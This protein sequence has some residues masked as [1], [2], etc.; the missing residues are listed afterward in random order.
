[1][2]ICVLVMANSR[3]SFCY[4]HADI[5][6]KK[7]DKCIGD[8]NADVENPILKAENFRTVLIL[9]KSL[10]DLGKR[11]KCR[12]ATAVGKQMLEN[13]MFIFEAVDFDRVSTTEKLHQQ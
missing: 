4:V 3:F 9:Q 8:P 12:I 10:G 13:N 1:M 2:A 7:V 5:D 11:L 6:L